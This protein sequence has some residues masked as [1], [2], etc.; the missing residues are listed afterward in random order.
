MRDLTVVVDTSA[1]LSGKPLCLDC[2]KMVTTPG[3]S[4]EIQPGGG[5]YRSF[6]FLLEKGLVL[7]S[8]SR[9]SVKRVE[10]AAEETGEQMRLSRVDKEVLAL[11]YEL[12]KKNR[13]RVVILTDDYSI[14]NLAVFL[15]I[16]Y[17]NV[18]QEKIKKKFKWVYL[19]SGCGKKFEKHVKNCP[20]CGAEIKTIVSSS[21]DVKK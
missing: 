6:Q 12:S 16:G 20:I 19:C 21:E 8:P 4:E 13:D 7:I 14:Q 1:V 17:L 2:K 9:E 15:N 5:A 11:A 10:R 18:S 3:V